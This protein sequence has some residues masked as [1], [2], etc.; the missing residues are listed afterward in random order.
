MTDGTSTA[1]DVR[2]RMINAAIVLFGRKGVDQVPLREL[3]ARAGV[4]LASVNYHFGSKEKLAT[5]V[6]EELS[7]RVNARRLRGLDRIEADCGRSGVRPAL[8]DIVASFIEPYV[9]AS[10]VDEG[11]LLSR[12]ILRHR[13]SPS[14]IT[15]TLMRRHFDPMA[16]R[17]IAAFAAACPD[18]AP[19]E[20]P[21]RYTF[22]VSTVV[23]T[24]T[25]RHK[26]S[27]LIRLSGGAADPTDAHALAAALAGFLYGAM[28]GPFAPS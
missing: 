12:L 28:R 5:L 18:V 19:E 23:L 15:A 24:M 22:M 21:W 27:R 1:V 17:Y 16:G 13:M 7:R 6:F 9:G 10:H 3:T 26:D 11:L 4:S 25:D 8:E 14:A 20:F 2:S